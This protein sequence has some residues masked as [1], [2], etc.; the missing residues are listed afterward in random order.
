MGDHRYVYLT[1]LGL[2]EMFVGFSLTIVV[3]TL[4]AIF[5]DQVRTAKKPSA[6]DSGASQVQLDQ[7][8][9]SLCR[10]R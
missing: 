9:L 2:G 4:I 1:L 5:G 8:L 7:P 3:G 6:V 10:L